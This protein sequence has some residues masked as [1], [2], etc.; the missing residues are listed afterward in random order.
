MASLPG[1]SRLKIAVAEQARGREEA[2]TKE[3][4]IR[5][6]RLVETTENRPKCHFSLTSI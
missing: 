1:L 4:K 5:K 2:L 3:R 6:G